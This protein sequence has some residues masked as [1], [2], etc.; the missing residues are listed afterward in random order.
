MINLANTNPA[1]LVPVEVSARELDARMR[2][3]AEAVCRGFS[4][5]IGQSRILH[6]RPELFSPAIVVE[7]D[8]T[9]A[10]AD[11]AHRARQL[12]HRLVA[13]DEEAIAVLND[14]WYTRQ[15]VARHTL[16]LTDLFFTRGRGDAAAVCE[17][18]PDLAERVR[19]AG[20]PRL[21]LLN[22]KVRAVARPPNTDAPIAVMSRFSRSNPFSLE[23]SEVLDNVVRKFRFG[24]VE[25]DFYRGF[26]EHCHALFD[27]FFAMVARLAEH[28]PDR[29]V[30]VRPHPS[31]RISTWEKLAGAHQNL[32][33]ERSGTAVELAERSAVVI[34][35]GCTTGLEAALIGRP[36]LAFTPVTS[37]DYDVAL[38]N[39][40][41]QEYAEE[42]VL[43]EAVANRIASP[44]SPQICAEHAWDRLSSDVGDGSGRTA[45]EIV[46]EALEEHYPTGLP[47]MEGRAIAVTRARLRAALEAMMRLVYRRNASHR[48][49]QAAYYAQKFGPIQAYELTDRLAVL[50]YPGL[51]AK[52]F[53][54]GWWWILRKEEGGLR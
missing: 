28:F 34:H 3:A 47:K 4:A 31:E 33:I 1:L 38:P 48:D 32:T 49:A 54:E 42:A 36:V 18:Y 24:P 22:P 12:G 8:V 51:Q 5:A 37:K 46:L 25:T 19:P 14:R 26:L 52:P 13:W 41:S 16:A 40:L 15:R 35:N 11:F 53:I 44:S 27:A 21:D 45:T 17:A 7:N 50:G 20:N 29:L 43:F 10:G 30:V 6:R 2:F 9:I 23:R 39:A